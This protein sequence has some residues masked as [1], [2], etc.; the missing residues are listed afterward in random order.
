MNL[1]NDALNVLDMP[2]YKPNN[3]PK[4]YEVISPEAPQSPHK[5]ERLEVHLPGLLP[6]HRPSGQQKLCVILEQTQGSPCSL[7]LVRRDE[8]LEHDRTDHLW[9]QR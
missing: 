7:L 1:T 5:E 6:K 4:D 9:T 8:E 2:A 3:D